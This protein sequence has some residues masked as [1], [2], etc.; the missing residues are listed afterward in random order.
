[1]GI[2]KIFVDQQNVIGGN[3]GKVGGYDRQEIQT[4]QSHV[5]KSH[6]NLCKRVPTVSN[7]T[8]N[9]FGSLTN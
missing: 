3:F 4:R 6:K 5:R 8:A 2:A 9:D 7:P 1:M